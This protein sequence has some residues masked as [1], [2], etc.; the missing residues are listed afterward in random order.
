MTVPEAALEN[1]LECLERFSN[2]PDTAAIHDPIYALLKEGGDLNE[3]VMLR[4]LMAHPAHP[5]SVELRAIL[6]PYLEWSASSLGSVLEGHGVVVNPDDLVA[7]VDMR[8]TAHKKTER[9]LRLEID[10]IESKLAQAERG[11][12]AVAALGALAL[13]FALFG[14]VIALGWMD[15]QW[16]DAP[17]PASVEAASQGEV[18][19]NP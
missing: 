15:V 17:V 3:Q 19:R 1:A 18:G 14:W 6:G 10:E 12:N 16:I 11:S 5:S 4:S 2:H 7:E 13:M 8:L 9:L